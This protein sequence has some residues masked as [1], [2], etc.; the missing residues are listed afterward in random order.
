MPLVDAIK[1]CCMLITKTW[2]QWQKWKGWQNTKLMHPFSYN[3]K[4]TITKK[5]KGWE[6]IKF[7]T[8]FKLQQKHNGSR[9]T[10]KVKEYVIHGCCC[11]I[12]EITYL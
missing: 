3:M 10:K 6:N 8:P 9:E 5:S 7:F 12:V 11:L 4:T 1:S 2:I